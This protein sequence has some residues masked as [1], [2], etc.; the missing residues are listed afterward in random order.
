MPIPEELRRS[1]ED[2]EVVFFCGAGVS[3][4]AGLPSFRELAS[5]I[6]TSLLPAKDNCESGSMAAL[7]WQ[8]FENDRFDE[9]LNILESPKLGGFEPKTIRE[10]VH[11][12]LS[13]PKINV[14]EQHL[15]LAQL[16]DSR[17]GSRSSCH[18]EF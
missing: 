5:R 6:L 1:H 16:A 18:D 11:Y 15:T 8:A 7:A 3:V 4:P 13:S 12:S 17:Y 10:Q 2:G 9:A 14:S